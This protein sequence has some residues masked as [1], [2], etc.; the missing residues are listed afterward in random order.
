MHQSLFA[1]GRGRL[2]R[3]WLAAVLLCVAMVWSTLASAQTSTYCPDPLTATVAN[4]GSVD[5]DVSDCDGPFD[6][7]MSGPIAPFAQHGGVTI[8]TNSGGVQFVTYA[9]SG[10]AATSD[11]IWLEDN[12]LGTVR[13]DLTISA[14]TSA[15][16]VSPASLPALTAGTAYAQTLSSAGG[17]TPYS[18]SLSS[19]ALPVGVSLTSAGAISGTPTRRG[20][21]SFSV[22]S[23]DA[24][25]D[26]VIK[27]Y[28][29]SVQDPTL[30]IAPAAAT[31]AQGVAFSQALT[32]SGGVAPH[33][34][35]LESGS[36]PAGIALSSAGVLSGA[37]SAAAGSYPVTLRVTDASTGPGSYF[38]LETF[39]LQVTA[40]PIIVVD[41]ASLSNATVGAAYNQTVSASGGTAP[42]AFAISAGALPA[43]LML[44]ANSGAITGT[45]TAAGSF[46]FTVRATDASSLT[47]TRAYTLTVSAPTLTLTPATGVLAVAYG[48]PYS[49]DFATS[50]GTASY[51]YSLAAGSLP[52][53][54][55][56]S[57]TGRLSGTPT[58][59]GNYNI[60]VR[61]TDNSTG[62]GAPFAIQNNYTLQVSASIITIDPPALPNG[63]AG[64]AYSA[65]LSAQGGVAPYTYSLLSG[66]LPIG[67]TFSSGGQ[68]SGV[69]RSDGNFSLTVQATDSNGQTG[70]K[71][72][73]FSIAPA[74]VVISPATLPGGTAGVAYSQTLSSSGGIAPYSYS[75]PS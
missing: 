57:S 30:S 44:D 73:T 42:Y 1:C 15:I 14:P 13:I 5:V 49:L 23:Q 68:V 10:N 70:Q 46:N 21:F 65:T 7:G 50:G 41:P 20:T 25:G 53:G 8:G 71:V 12:D 17:V 2:T 59:P 26:F 61:S 4:G 38:E 40:T 72:Y 55:T 28:T 47:G 18:Y 39:T 66:A 74:S 67:M 54:M 69:P 45:P 16:T 31:A 33:T 32:P 60:T 51:S 58:V 9:H 63:V 11:V 36:L 56:L 48:V 22:R 3:C 6:G 37:T 75:I 34:F 27:G 29:G 43:G 19:G 62:T 24:G 52:L 35:A 64:T